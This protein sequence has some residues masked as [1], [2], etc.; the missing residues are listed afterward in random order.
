MREGLVTVTRS[1]LSEARV[2]SVEVDDVTETRGILL[3]RDEEFH[4]IIVT[5]PPG[6]GKS[7]LIKSLKGW[8]QEGYLDL[9]ERGWWR[10]RILA[11]RPREVHFG[12]P[13]YGMK[14]SRTVVDPTWLESLPALDLTRIRLPPE[15]TGFLAPNWRQR[16]VFDFQLPPAAVIYAAR[17]ERARKGT[18][19]ADRHLSLEI[20]EMQLEVYRS[21][22]ALF[23]NGGLQVYVRFTFGG[24]PRRLV[25]AERTGGHEGRSL[26]ASIWPQLR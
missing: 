24:H 25:G 5:G 9:A 7:T 11:Y 17:R 23:H 14:R 21:V 13:F 15:K 22:A 20:I 19:V 6:T 12:L 26:A 18:H 1:T 8:P 4:K 2:K 16:F 10:S 3:A